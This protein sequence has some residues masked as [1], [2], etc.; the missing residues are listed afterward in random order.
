MLPA[1]SKKTDNIVLAAAKNGVKEIVEK[2]LELYPAVIHDRNEEMKN[3]LLLAAENRHASI[4]NLLVNKNVL[5]ET[6]FLRVD[7]NDNNVL[8]VA[9]DYKVD[10][11][12]PIPGV[13]LQM[14]W[15]IKW[16]QVLALHVH[17]NF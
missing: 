17:V 16:F 9:A 13:A 3:I 1:K 4:Y 7:V 6:T 12:W 15:E 14:Q 2:F 8:H 5:T 10:R 11:P